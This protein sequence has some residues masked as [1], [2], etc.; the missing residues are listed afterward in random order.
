MLFVEI[1]GKR[2][3]YDAN[4]G[5]AP[6]DSHPPIFSRFK[7]SGIDPTWEIFARLEYV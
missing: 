7:P 6:D 3:V 2:I 5:A 4:I 1:A